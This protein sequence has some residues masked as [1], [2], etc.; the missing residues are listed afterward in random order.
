MSQQHHNEDIINVHHD[1]AKEARKQLSLVNLYQV[2]KSTDLFDK[3][4]CETVA[5]M[6]FGLAGLG[7]L[8]SS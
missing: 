1:H 6:C 3:Y 5:G 2:C 7:K 4:C 8:F